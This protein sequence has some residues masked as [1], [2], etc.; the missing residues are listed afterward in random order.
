[1]GRKRKFPL[2]YKLRPWFRGEIT[3]SSD[4]DDDFV[5][6]VPQTPITPREPVELPSDAPSC[7]LSG[8]GSSSES[9]SRNKHSRRKFRRHS[10]RSCSSSTS[11]GSG[12]QHSRRE[13]PEIILPSN[14]LHSDFHSPSHSRDADINDEINFYAA[15]DQQQ[16]VRNST[17][18]DDHFSDSYE[19]ADNSDD[20]VSQFHEAEENSPAPD[21]PPPAPEAHNE[22]DDP[23]QG[24]A[25]NGSDDLAPAD[26]DPDNYHDDDDEDIE[27]LNATE[28]E[29]HYFEYLHEL[30]KDWLMV[31][32]DHHVSK[33][34]TDAFWALACK[35]MHQLFESK[36]RNEVRRKTPKF[37]QLRKSLNDKVPE[38]NMEIG[39]IDRNGDLTV[40]ENLR[41]TP[42]KQYPPSQFKKAYEIATVK[43]R[44]D[45]HKINKYFS[46]FV[47]LCFR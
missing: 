3:S 44:F 13:N 45:I 39:F 36:R 22:S 9:S 4:S 24:E 21:D 15:N 2:S 41:S 30:S 34:A 27:P 37:P 46:L 7:P 42:L 26:D 17:A 43:V 8:T 23:P 19:A 11:A 35:K 1:M 6:H 12:S 20:R 14:P 38:I 29:K 33:K 10:H 32:I 47:F 18:P 28:N 40:K 31:E 16:I 25:H 5:A